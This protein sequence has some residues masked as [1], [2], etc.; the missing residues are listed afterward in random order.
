MTFLMM[1]LS[2]KTTGEL[3][4]VADKQKLKNAILHRLN[5]LLS[6]GKVVE[7]YFTEFMVQ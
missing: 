1:I 6:S 2:S 3:L 5:S 7:V 4:S